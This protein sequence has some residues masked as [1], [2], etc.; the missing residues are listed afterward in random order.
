[1]IILLDQGTPLPIR[2]Y[3]EGHR[4][5]TAAQEGWSALSNGDLLT[6]AERAG[7]DLLITTDKNLPYQQNLTNRKIA[8]LV[9][10]QQQ[11]PV[12]QQHI[13][14]VVE[15][16]NAV[17]PGSFT[18]VQ[19]AQIDGPT[20]AL[21]SFLGGERVDQVAAGGSSLQSLPSRLLRQHDFP[22]PDFY[23][24]FRARRQMQGR[25]HIG[26]NRYSPVRSNR[27]LLHG[28]LPGGA[29]RN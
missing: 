25:A 22:A 28:R 14:R 4:V 17:T 15:A 10:G 3:L 26:R 23:R 8:V 11:W 16:V 19:I 13:A 27:D 29:G 24:E 5:R 6:A 18:E 7:F 21:P 1:M 12:L 20:F 2:Q 9:L